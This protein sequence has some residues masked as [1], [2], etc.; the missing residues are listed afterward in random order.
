MGLGRLAPGA[1]EPTGEMMDNP[2]LVNMLRAKISLDV[3]KKKI[4]NSRCRFNAASDELIAISNAAREGGMPQKDVDD[5]LKLVIEKANSE[6]VRLKA[7]GDHFMN[8]CVNGDEQEYES[9]MRTL[10][11]EGRALVPE[12]LKHIEEEN[13]LKRKGVLDALGRLGDKTPEVVK[14]VRLMLGDRHPAVRAQAAKAVA[15]LAG[16]DTGKELIRDL[17]RRL[18][19]YTDGFAMALGYLD[20]KEAVPVLTA[21][22]ERSSDKDARLAA[23]FS[24]GLLQARDKAAVEALLAA[25]LDP[26][27]PRLR[28]AAAKSLGQIAERRAV[29]YIIRSFQRYQDGRDELI[30]QLRYFKTI[31]VAEFLIRCVEEDSPEIRRAANDTLKTLT[32]ANV[33]T[34][35]EWRSVLPVIRDRPDW[36]PETPAPAPK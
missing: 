20:C 30:G 36:L 21:V 24:L 17:E 14:S 35:E 6:K 29:D 16:P 4:E 22:L 19:E 23:A 8:I 25:V 15:A 11:R 27:D 3:I 1:D 32:G 33:D 18:G 31:P 13:E 5:L 2:A 7:M 28:T 9:L 12:L 26:H 34:A 10:L